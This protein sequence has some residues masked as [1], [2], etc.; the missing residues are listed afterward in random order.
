M[1]ILILEAEQWIQELTQQ[2]F[3]RFLHHHQIYRASTEREGLILLQAVKPQL[4]I[5]E[6]HPP[7]I[8]GL[9]FI[10]R[11]RGRESQIPILLIADE[12][13]Y[14][15]LSQR[16]RELKVHSL[17]APTDMEHFSRALSRLLPPPDPFPQDQDPIETA[18][19]ILNRLRTEIDAD[20]VLLMNNTGE[21]LAE[22]AVEWWPQSRELAVLL[23]AGHASATETAKMLGMATPFQTILYRGEGGGMV[24]TA[25]IND[26]FLLGIIFGERTRTGIVTYFTSRAIPHLAR[27]LEGY[28]PPLP[29]VDITN[30][31]MSLLDD[32]L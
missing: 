13:D 6:D 1:R 12:K 32:L 5:V 26:S 2:Q 16:V 3:A 20:L 4:V 18:Q 22:S 23:S 9:R 14:L 10:E 30:E 7:L 19:E 25:R 31:A 8:S 27:L 28:Q 15:L 21:I 11:V 24:Y 29:E 17:I